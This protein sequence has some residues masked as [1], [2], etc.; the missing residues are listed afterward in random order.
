MAV[1]F[2]FLFGADV[3]AR[4]QAGG[5]QRYRGSERQAS[6][7]LRMNCRTLSSVCFWLIAGQGGFFIE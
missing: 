3:A 1:Y 7:A 4:S 5:A 2:L 6:V